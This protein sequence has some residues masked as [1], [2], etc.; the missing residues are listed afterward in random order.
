[1]TSTSSRLGRLER[2]PLVFLTA[3]IAAAVCIAGCKPHAGAVT[4]T[5]SQSPPAAIVNGVSISRAVYD[6][7]LR[8]VASQMRGNPSSFTADQ[9]KELLENLIRQELVVQQ[10]QKD[11]LAQDPPVLNALEL[12]RLDIFERAALQRYLKDHAPTEQELRAQYETWAASYPRVK[13]RAS[14]I[15]VETEPYAEKIID[16]LN[17]GANFADLAKRDSMDPSKEQGGDIG[18]FTPDRMIPEFVAAVAALKPGEYTRKP[19]HTT[20]G[21]HIIK[22]EEV[23]DVTPP[24][25]DSIRQ[26]LF[27]TV[28]QKKFRDY[29][30]SLGKT[31]QIERKKIT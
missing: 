22:L 3:T 19:V 20:Y 13:Y 30:D 18:W 9:R 21:W 23:Q 31:A 4:S 6:L 7:Y 11:G 29:E 14:H 10:S 8:E 15:L 2:L 24:A 1:M 28:A 26:Q 12:A 5:A 16:E 17:K 27:A 25:Y